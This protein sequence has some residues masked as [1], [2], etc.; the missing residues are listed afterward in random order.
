MN[1]WTSSDLLFYGGLCLMAAAL[2]IGAAAGLLLHHSGKQLRDRLD[3]EY[4]PKRH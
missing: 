4:G 2:L 3:E 1:G